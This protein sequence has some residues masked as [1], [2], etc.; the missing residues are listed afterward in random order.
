M[1][2]WWVVV[3]LWIEVMAGLALIGAQLRAVRKRRVTSARHEGRLEAL[4]WLDWS[5]SISYA[6]HRPLTTPLPTPHYPDVSATVVAT[7]HVDPEEGR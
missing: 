4:A 7:D 1:V 2:A 3:A 5:L 6:H